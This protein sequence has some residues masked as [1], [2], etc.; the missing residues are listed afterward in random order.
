MEKQEKTKISWPLIG[1]RHISGFLEKTI[2]NDII[3]GTYVFCGP[4]NLGKTTTA[5]FFAQSILCK[6]RDSDSLPCGCC[7]SCL[8]F[9]RQGESSYSDFYLVKKDKDKK[10][11]SVEQ[12]R[13]FINSLSMSSFLNSYKIGIIKH[14]DSLSI[15]ASNALLKT[16]E[17]PRKDVVVILVANDVE[18]LPK[19]IVSRSKVLNFYP[20]QTDEIYD[21]MVN[22]HRAGRTQAQN[23]AHLSAGRPA[24]ALKFFEDRDFYD[25]YLERAKVFVAFF[26]QCLGER[27]I[28]INGIFD[29]KLSGQ[30]AVRTAKRIL[31]IWQGVI[32]DL[33]LMGSNHGNIIQHKPLEPDLKNV[34]SRMTDGKAADILELIRN[35]EKKLSRNVSPRLI[36][37]SVAIN[38]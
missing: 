23:C 37:D 25:S 13:D 18:E 30:E 33:V 21:F 29:A 26:D 9:K 35:G 6:D 7:Q 11:I 5:V 17:E 4:D 8:S 15:E 27:L 20:V 1:N 24:I 2:A 28:A 32:R 16:L 22:D 34:R 14:A 19:T 38:L 10:N 12:V 3:S 36:L 31:E